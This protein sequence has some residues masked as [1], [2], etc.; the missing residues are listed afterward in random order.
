[1]DKC[2][3]CKIADKEIPAG[4]VYEDNEIVVFNDVNPQAPVH[5]LVI[6]KK[7]IE[8]LNVVDEYT[9]AGWILKIFEVIKK[10]VKEKKLENNG[11]RVV[12]NCGKDA[13]QAVGHVH[14]HILGGRKLSWPP[15]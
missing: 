9:D 2:I 6:P 7:H 8:S 13:G 15:G 10:V 12:I 4:I 3:F 14:F 11:Y 5:M 1:M